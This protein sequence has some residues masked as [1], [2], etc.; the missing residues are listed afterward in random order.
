MKAIEE[1]IARISRTYDELYNM[2]KHA[3]LESQRMTKVLMDSEIIPP[4]KE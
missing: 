3:I 2:A 4:F 1:G